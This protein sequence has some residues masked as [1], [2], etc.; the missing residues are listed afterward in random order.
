MK[1]NGHTFYIADIKE[2]ATR[3]MRAVSLTARTMEMLQ[4]FKLAHHILQEALVLQGTQLIVNGKKV[5][6]FSFV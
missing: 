4:N 5:Y 1:A 3:E 2:E 6:F